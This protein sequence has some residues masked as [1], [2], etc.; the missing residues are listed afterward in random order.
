MNN[1]SKIILTLLVSFSAWGQG[2]TVTPTDPHVDLKSLKKPEFKTQP[3]KNIA[4]TYLSPQRRDTI[5]NKYLPEELKKMDE[6]DKDIFYKS[7]LN[8]DNEK[9]IQK[10]PF[11]KKV[12]I[13]EI[14][15]SL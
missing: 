10:Y 4:T 9:L 1:C 13:N 5:L 2:F 3:K 14:K 6:F 15:K 7:L 12:N 8:Y 11:L